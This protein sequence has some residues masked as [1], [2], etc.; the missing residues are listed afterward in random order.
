MQKLVCS[1]I[2]RDS[3]GALSARHF[4]HGTYLGFGLWYMHAYWWSASN[5]HFSMTW[6]TKNPSTAHDKIAARKAKMFLRVRG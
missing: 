3:R 4:A 1:N 5:G 6:I 2:E